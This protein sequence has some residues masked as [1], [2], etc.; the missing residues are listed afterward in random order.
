MTDVITIN[1]R[2]LARNRA[3]AV[4]TAIVAI[5]HA[6]LLAELRERTQ[7]KTTRPDAGHLHGLHK[8][9]RNVARQSGSAQYRCVYDRIE[10]VIIERTDDE[11][12]NNS[13]FAAEAPKLTNGDKPWWVY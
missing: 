2:E 1:D 7:S 10:H 9:N 4:G 6:R 11:L 8:A 5:E 3:A 12:T 13:D